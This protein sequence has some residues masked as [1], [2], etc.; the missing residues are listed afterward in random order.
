MLSTI[1]NQGLASVGVPL[2]SAKVLL[3]TAG[4][5]ITAFGVANY[6][7]N[8]SAVAAMRARQCLAMAT[9]AARLMLVSI[10][11]L[12]PLLGLARPELT[13]WLVDGVP[14]RHQQAVSDLLRTTVALRRRFPARVSRRLLAVRVE[15]GAA[16]KDAHRHLAAL[17]RE[18][19]EGHIFV[20]LR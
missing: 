5:T 8:R 3:L 14:H 11:D 1:M 7:A 12:A 20:T 2:A 9:E 17:S 13:R 6:R 16:L 10:E 15:R 18:S 19:R 4:A